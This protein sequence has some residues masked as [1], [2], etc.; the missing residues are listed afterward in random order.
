[1]NKEN[2]VHLVTPEGVILAVAEME[3]PQGGEALT[4]ESSD[5]IR[6]LQD[7]FTKACETSQAEIR[8]GRV[9][10]TRDNLRA[11]LDRAIAEGQIIPGLLHAARGELVQALHA[12][13]LPLAENM[14]DQVMG[15]QVLMDQLTAFMD[16][17]KAMF[18]ETVIQGRD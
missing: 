8:E 12:N 4:P 1:M 16:G 17:L 14:A 11:S 7:R 9:P 6:Q 10:L 3:T 15:E 5:M 2:L 18:I 13:L